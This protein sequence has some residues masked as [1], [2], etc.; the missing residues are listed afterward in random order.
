M[1]DSLEAQ[2]NSL[3]LPVARFSPFQW[4]NVS[5]YVQLKGLRRFVPLHWIPY[6][7]FDDV[8]LTFTFEVKGQ[9]PAENIRIAIFRGGTEVFPG[10]LRWR[11]ETDA[12]CTYPITLKHVP[13]SGEYVVDV[14][15]EDIGQDE[16]DPNRGYWDQR[17]RLRVGSFHVIVEDKPILGALLLATGAGLTLL[18]QW[19]N[20]VL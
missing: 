2:T 11:L 20:R 6:R 16:E 19:L 12:K 1:N 18:V 14:F 10:N 15:F 3:R 13:Y 5:G 7:T 9:D 17:E 8:K 4:K